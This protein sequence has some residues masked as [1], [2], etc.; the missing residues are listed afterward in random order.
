[1]THAGPGLLA[2]AS[3]L[4]MLIGAWTAWALAQRGHALAAT[5][6]LAW[7]FLLPALWEPPPADRVDQLVDEL[8]AALEA[9]GSPDL[10]D[11]AALGEALRA[12]RRR[13]DQLLVLRRQSEGMPDLVAEIDRVIA[14]T[15]AEIDGV[16][17][18]ARRLRVE[19][20]L[21]GLSGS[22]STTLAQL[23]ARVSALGE[24]ERLGR[25]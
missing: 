25:V 5:A 1:M 16:F 13:V 14:Q 6:L 17:A 19:V 18:A 11:T 8:R 7:P 10:C 23:Q 21:A 3:L 9:A 15:R 12:A 22:L 4:W 2:G 20:G 24:V